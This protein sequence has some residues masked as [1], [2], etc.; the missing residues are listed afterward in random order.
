MQE[1]SG[2]STTPTPQEA[3]IAKPGTDAVR[4]Y[5][6]YMFEVRGTVWVELR[7]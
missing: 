4:K 1:A 5:T 6:M 2:L 7:K 3:S